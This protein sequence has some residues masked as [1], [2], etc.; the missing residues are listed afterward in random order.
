MKKSDN[1]HFFNTIGL[2]GKELSEAIKQNY[3]QDSKVL[4]FFRFNPELKLSKY[5]VHE[6]L[7]KG[8]FINKKTPDSSIGR[9]LYTLMKEGLV[10]KTSEQ[11]KERHGKMNYLWKLSQR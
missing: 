7:I 1:L 4:L 10:L 3:S 8:K 5:E 2:E 9:A 6:A 11:K